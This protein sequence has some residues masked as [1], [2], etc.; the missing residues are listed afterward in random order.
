MQKRFIENVSKLQ[1]AGDTLDM[2][3]VHEN[4]PF[5][6]DVKLR[7]L[8]CICTKPL[9]TGYPAIHRNNG[10][11]IIVGKSCSDKFTNTYKKREE[12]KRET[13]KKI[14]C[15]IPIENHDLT[16][17]VRAAILEYVNTYKIAAYIK[18]LNMYKVN[19]PIHTLLLEN[20]DYK[21]YEC[22]CGRLSTTITCPFCEQ[23]KK[24]IRRFLSKFVESMVLKY[25]RQEKE[26]KEGLKL[27]FD[28]EDIE[29]D[30][31]DETYGIMVGSTI[32]V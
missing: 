16:L 6:G 8:L 23:D 13:V 15:G 1:N 12:T 32:Y 30:W 14:E 18:L 21:I 25:K 5:Y 7:N 2:W 28:I 24:T 29:F 11:Q 3:E 19:S 9:G 26:K 22:S 10:N 20:F 4:E 31:F 17:Y 27:Q